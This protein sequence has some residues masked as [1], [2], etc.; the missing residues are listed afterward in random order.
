MDIERLTDQDVIDLSKIDMT[1]ELKKRGYQMGWYKPVTYAGVIYILVN[2]A[3]PTLVKIG[4]ADNLEKRIKVLNSNSGLPDPYHCFAAYKVKKR[5][6]DLQLHKLIDTLDSD[7]RH[8]ANREFYEMSKE[9]AYGI[10]SAIAQING[11]ENL[12]ATNPLND[13]YFLAPANNSVVPLDNSDPHQKRHKTSRLSFEELGISIGTE[14]VFAENHD[15][16]VTV[17][18]SKTMVSYKGQLYKMSAAVKQIKRDLGTQ[19]KSEA[20]QSGSFFLY[21]GEILTTRRARMQSDTAANDLAS[22]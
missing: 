13:T 19:T 6:E 15:I 14:L 5:L 4:Y 17:A 16:K 2:P 7:L 12:L 20:Y 11:D 3:F 18:D 10:L 9:K 21:E 1:E 22:E 8:S